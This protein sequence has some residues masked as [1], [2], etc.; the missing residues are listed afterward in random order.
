MSTH[1]LIG[2]KEEKASGGGY[3][4]LNP[5]QRGAKSPF[6]TELAA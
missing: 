5:K 3:T 2:H 6:M 1:D 4:K